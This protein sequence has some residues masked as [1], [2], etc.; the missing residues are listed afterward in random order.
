[1]QL[2][3]YVFENNIF[4]STYETFCT[5]LKNIK[6]SLSPKMSVLSFCRWGGSIALP[7]KSFLKISTLAIVQ[8]M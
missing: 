4:C 2:C 5:Y 3:C 6:K 8:Y 7:H 1:M